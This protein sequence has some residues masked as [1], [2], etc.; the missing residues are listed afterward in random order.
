MN[1]RLIGAGLLAGLV[2]NIGEGLLH[3]VIYADASTEAMRNLGREM[4][5]SAFG[6]TQL[7]LVTFA[8]G[9]LGMV[10]YAAVQPKW[11]AGLGTAVRVGLALWLL[12][13]VYSAIYLTA[14]FPG[15]IP[16]ALAWGVARR[17]AFLYPLAIAAGSLVF[18]EK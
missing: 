13:A 16:D 10:I 4:I 7:V 2:L 5:A 8:Q 18:K 14:G 9:F 17:E 12:S 11:G 15:L 1:K 6:M 3:G